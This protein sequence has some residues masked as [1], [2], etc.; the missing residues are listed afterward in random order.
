MNQLEQILGFL[1]ERMEKHR[2]KEQV[3]PDDRV[4]SLA[5]RI[6][7]YEDQLAEMSRVL[8]DAVRT[9]ESVVVSSL[10]RTKILFSTHFVV[11]S[12]HTTYNTGTPRID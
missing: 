7:A 10:N 8:S 5:K 2:S 11:S 4:S 12:T 9:W 6:Q 3:L 1:E